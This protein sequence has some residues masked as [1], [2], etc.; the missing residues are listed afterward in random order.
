M[1]YVFIGLA[2]LGLLLAALYDRPGARYTQCPTG[3]PYRRWCAACGQCQVMYGAPDDGHYWSTQ[4]A[5]HTP[6]CACHRDVT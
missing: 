6:E 4:G 5:R 2:V 1:T 3:N